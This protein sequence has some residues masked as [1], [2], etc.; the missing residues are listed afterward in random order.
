MQAFNTIF[1]ELSSVILDIKH[2][3]IGVKNFPKSIHLV[4]VTHNIGKYT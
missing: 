2:E 4:Q 1:T 3:Q